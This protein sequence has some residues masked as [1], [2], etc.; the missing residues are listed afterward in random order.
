MPSSLRAW[1][2]ASIISTDIFA[3]SHQF[4]ADRSATVV[5][6]LPPVSQNLDQQSLDPLL[7]GKRV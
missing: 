2:H 3:D 7:Y 1:N 4:I 5:F 6:H